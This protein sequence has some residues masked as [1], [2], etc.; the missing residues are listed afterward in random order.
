MACPN[1]AGVV[2][3]LRQYVVENFPDIADDN[4]EVAAMVNRLLMSTADIALNTNGQPY[5]VRKQG[6]GLANL[7]NAIATDAYISTRD[8]DGKVMD[9][10]KL[11]LG[12]DPEKTGVYEMNFSIVNFGEKDVTYD[13]GYYVMTEGV[14]ETK[15]NAGETTVTEEAY[16]L[17]GASV[18]ITSVEG[19]TQKGT[20]ISVDAGSTADVK[21]TITLSDSDKASS[22]SF[23]ASAAW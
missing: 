23:A 21:V 14:S 16:I 5:A 19:G 7:T 1:I 10:T 3:L 13:L 18:E 6:A 2:V 4:V 9:K 12:D 20:K 22:W 11:E 15:T 8:T 17:E